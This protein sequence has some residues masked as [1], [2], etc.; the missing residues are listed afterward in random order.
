MTITQTGRNATFNV[1][2][3]RLVLT[4]YPPAMRSQTTDGYGA[5]NCVFAGSCNFIDSKN[6]WGGT[7]VVNGVSYLPNNVVAIDPGNGS[8]LVAFRYGLFA[9]GLDMK[10]QPKYA[11]GYPVVSIPDQGPGFGSNVTA[12]DLKVYVCVGQASC[13]SGG[14]LTLTSRVKLT[15]PVNT[16]PAPLTRKVEV[17]SW[18]EQ[19]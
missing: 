18:S 12:V 15:D 6:N 8:G 4:Y 11:F 9:R 7:F 16:P 17:L 13:A 14:T 1:D 10:G 19:R 2:A 5:T 3:V